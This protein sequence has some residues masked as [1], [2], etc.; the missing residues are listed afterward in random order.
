MEPLDREN[1]DVYQCFIALLA[2]ALRISARLPRGEAPLRDQL[3]R[4]AMSIPL[5]IAEG[6][7]KPTGPD[8]SR[9]HAVAR[10][11]ALECG[12]VLDVCRVGRMALESDIDE[13][14]PR[15]LE[16]SRC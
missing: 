11:S 10:G 6:V 16:S 4:A 8:R 13:A 15:S 2:T 5:N 3:K 9:F 14:K 12:A 1:L 7:G